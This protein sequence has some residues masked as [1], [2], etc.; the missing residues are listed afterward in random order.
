MQP[1]S[2][3]NKVVDF[4]QT[5]LQI[6]QKQAI[7]SLSDAEYQLARKQLTEEINEFD[8]ADETS[9]LAGQIDALADLVYFAIG[10]MY[11]IG[12]TPEEIEQVFNAVHAANMT[13]K[14]GVKA[15]R[16]AVG[17]VDAVKPD[18]FHDPKHIIQEIIDVRRQKIRCR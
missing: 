12:L 4:N 18:E 14:I 13:K 6:P 7:N 8:L 17:A 1:K 9:D 5:I 10:I 2:I 15:S 11:K 3:I 16:A